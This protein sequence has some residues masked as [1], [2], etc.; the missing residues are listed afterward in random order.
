MSHKE[1]TKRKHRAKY[2]LLW[3]LILII[4]A[5]AMELIQIELLQLMSISNYTLSSNEKNNNSNNNNHCFMLFINICGNFGFMFGI[6]IAYFD[7][8]H[9]NFNHNF[10]KSSEERRI[11]IK[12]GESHILKQYFVNDM[13]HSIPKKP[14]QGLNT[15][16]KDKY[17]TIMKAQRSRMKLGCLF[18]VI[19]F[20]II[21]SGFN[22]VTLISAF[23][24]A[25][26]ANKHNLTGIIAIVTKSN[27][28]NNNNSL[29]II[30]HFFQYLLILLECTINLWYFRDIGKQEIEKFHIKLKENQQNI[31]GSDLMKQD[32]NKS[33][34]NRSSQYGTQ[35]SLER[36]IDDKNAWCD[37]TV[38]MC[39]T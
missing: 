9:G 21:I 3:L 35:K 2:G 16:T 29:F 18:V 20:T 4:C 24:I 36:E 38:A 31:T 30:G 14:K 26:K 13:N 10:R 12:R 27:K 6:L 11:I 25:S 32:E 7:W 22:V 34:G 5:V 23:E 15:A 33:I 19:V 28:H 17:R 37:S 39:V 1:E 8:K